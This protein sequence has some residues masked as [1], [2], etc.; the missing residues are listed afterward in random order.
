MP[1]IVPN[2][3]PAID[4]LSGENIRVLSRSRAE[5]LQ[6]SGMPRPLRICFLNL[7]PVKQPYEVQM[8]R[9]LSACPLPVELVPVKLDS[10]QTHHGEEEHIE[11]FYSG[12]QSLKEEQ[13]DGMIVTGAPVEHLRFED[14]DYWPE[15]C[16][17]MDWAKI[18]VTSSLYLCWGVLA[19]L[20]HHFGIEKI[21]L[22]RKMIGVFDHVILRKDVPLVQGMDDWITAPHTRETGFRPEDVY[23]CGE[24][25]VLAASE[26][27]GPLLCMAHDGREI[28]MMG[29]PEY[30]SDTIHSEY[31]RD[32][33]RGMN[34]PLPPHLYVNDDVDGAA[35]LRWRADGSVLYTNW[36]SRYAA[37]DTP[38]H[39]A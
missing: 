1:V 15:L 12:F 37:K 24:L 10:H 33:G 11:R 27:A 6:N 19:G 38:W 39:F 18:N 17:L 20:Y 21:E 7:M 22:S 4:I 14:I 28:F 5:A 3:F 16:A 31:V 23:A 2:D 13:F 34:I 30:G 29:H 36:L 25:T 8:I 32:V 26:E 35:P 9:L